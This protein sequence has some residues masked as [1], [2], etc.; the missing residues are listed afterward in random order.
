M[1]YLILEHKLKGYSV[2]VGIADT[3]ENVIRLF[4]N[5][6]EDELGVIF[7]YENIMERIIEAAIWQPVWVEHNN[8]SLTFTIQKIE[9][10]K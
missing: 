1:L 2:P 4:K 9:L 7:N 8:I 3:P 10:N 6:V 5:E